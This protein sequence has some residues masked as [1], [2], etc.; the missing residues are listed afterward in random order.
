MIFFKVM[1]KTDKNNENIKANNNDDKTTY[2]MI[3][4]KNE[5]HLIKISNISRIVKF[6]QIYPLPDTDKHIL[7]VANISGEI[8]PILNL[9][10]ILNI[11]NKDEINTDSKIVITKYKDFLVGFLVDDVID[12]IELSN[13]DLKKD[14]TKTLENEFIKGEFIYLT[15]V[16]AE[17]DIQ[18]I[19]MNFKNKK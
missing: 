3:T 15:D 8:I 11:P 5:K 13:E 14:T 7:G 2:L 12:M 9:H 18:K 6:K 1:S 17:I 10:L 19:I 16:I 4:L